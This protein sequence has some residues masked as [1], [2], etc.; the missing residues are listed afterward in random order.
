MS[1]KINNS[2]TVKYAARAV[3]VDAPTTP[4]APETFTRDVVVGDVTY[5]AGMLTA[6]AAVSHM[7]RIRTAR[8]I[9]LAGMI[10]GIAGSF[11]KAETALAEIF[12]YVPDGFSRA[13]MARTAPILAAVKRFGARIAADET[14]TPV[15]YGTR[16]R[17]SE[18]A[19]AEILAALDALFTAAGRDADAMAGHVTRILAGKPTADVLASHIRAEIPAAADATTARREAAAAKRAAD[20]AA[21]KDGDGDDSDSD[22]DGET[23]APTATA[24][25]PT[26]EPVDV[27]RTA[28]ETARAA[29]ESVA[30]ASL[31]ADDVAALESLVSLVSEMAADA[32]GAVL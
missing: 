29:L 23:V 19:T 25:T 10:Y 27:F 14:G 5:P 15:M 32:A 26:A 7:P 11:K 9:A 2:A 17:Y 31:T 8:G 3:V 21:G 22:S 30:P 18:D 24:A 4:D 12:G 16:A 6:I 13:G 1:I 28:L 20:R